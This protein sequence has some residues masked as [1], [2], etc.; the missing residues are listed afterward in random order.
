MTPRPNEAARLTQQLLDA[1]LSRKQ[2]ADIIGRDAS[3]VSQFFTKNKGAAFVTALQEVVQAVD[4]GERDLDTLHATAQPHVKRRLASTGREARVRGKNVVGTL[5]KSAAGRAGEQAIA[6]G[7]SH[8]AAVVHAAGQAGGRLAFTVRMKRDQYE[9]SAG[10]DDDSP[11]L[12]RGVVPRADDTEE[13]SYGSSQTGGFEAAEWSQ[14][15]ADHYGDVTAAVQ[16]WM[17]ETGRA[18]P[19]AHIQYLEV[20]TWLPRR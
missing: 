5:G 9:L 14:R 12:K 15:V 1:G 16:A 13:R 17:V 10:S 19:A 4:A 8:L 3:L 18:I 20:R 2:V 6:H 11:G 7:A